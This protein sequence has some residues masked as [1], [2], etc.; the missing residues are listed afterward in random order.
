RFETKRF[1]RFLLLLHNLCLNLTKIG[2]K[3][4]ID[5]VYLYHKEESLNLTKIGLKPRFDVETFFCFHVNRFE[6]D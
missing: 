1:I 4:G 5:G 6:F 2:L 3:L